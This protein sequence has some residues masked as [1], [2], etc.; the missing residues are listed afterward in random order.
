MNKQIITEILQ[1]MTGILNNAQLEFLSGVLEH[2]LWE[3][4]IIN[5]T[6]QQNDSVEYVD[7]FLS[8]KKLEGCS[9][10]CE[11]SVIIEQL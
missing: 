2:I 4:A 7:R 5:I 11:Q 3:M 6:E 8:A 9:V 10:L 1:E